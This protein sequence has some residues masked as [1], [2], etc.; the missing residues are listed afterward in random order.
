MRR[1]FAASIA[2]ALTA[3]TLTVFAGSAPNAQSQSA[4]GDPQGLSSGATR[5]PKE[6]E[7]ELLVKFRRGTSNGART[8]A[9]VNAGASLI[10]AFRAVP[11]LEQVRLPQGMSVPAALERYRSRADVVYAEPNYD[12]HTLQSQT[13]PSDPDFGQLWGLHNVGQSGGTVNADINAPEA[14]NITTGSS[15]VVVAVIDT[16]TDYMHPDLA[17]NMFRNTADCNA[18]GVDDDGNGYIDD[19]YGIDTANHD[20]DPMDDRGHGT[21]TAGTIGAAG[22]NGVGVVGV[23]WNV[24]V[25]AC[26][27][28]NASGFGSI[29]DAVACLDYVRIMKDRG[30]NI[31]ATSNS[32]GGGGYSQ[33]LY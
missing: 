3:L 10:R 11:D 28:L 16:G 12:L 2:R 18:N 19:C 23:N 13:M 14:W 4:A 30:V 21:H 15:N 9:R 17:A 5:A 25:M 26:K 33:A 31:V 6:V 1:S 29:A 27:F 7:G 32:W 8:L 22:N 20:S 24:S